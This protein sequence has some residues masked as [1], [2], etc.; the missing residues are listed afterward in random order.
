M[1]TNVSDRGSRSWYPVFGMLAGATMWGVVWYPMRLLEANGLQGLWLALIL[2]ATALAVSLPRTAVAAREFSRRPMWLLLLIVTAGWT[3]VAFVVA[4]LE[5][6]ILRVLL[7][8]YLSPLWATLMAWRF[9]HERISR[10]GFASLGVAMIGALLMLWN[11]VLDLPW[12]QGKADWMAL[13]A[14]FAFALS[15]IVTRK[16]Q[17]I[18]VTA[19]VLC[20]W[21][22]VIIVALAMIGLFSIPRPTVAWPVFAGAVALGCGGILIMTVFV[23]YGVTHMPVH[24][25]AVLALIELVAGAISQQLLTD[26]IVSVRE[27]I[28]GIL[29]V[30]GAYLAARVSVKLE[31]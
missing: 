17:E 19:K 30:I 22:G 28:G 1:S 31:S 4:V 2:Y 3:N 12:P 14:G 16:T 23:Q 20:V 29:I 8:F 13:S 18:S 6:N 27:W 7:L 5:G 15:N 10:V 24:R 11:P 25:S 21:I 26:E 9:L